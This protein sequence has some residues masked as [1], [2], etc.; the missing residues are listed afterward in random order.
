[1]LDDAFADFE[2]EVQS[3]E[4]GVA[5]LEI[6]HDAQGVQI[7]IEVEAVFAHGCIESFFAGVAE[8]G[9]ADVVDKSQRLGEIDV[10]AEC[11]GDGARDL[12]DFER[13]GE[14]V[15]EMVGITAGEDLSFRFQAAEGTGMDDAV[16][17]TLEI[18]AV[19]VRG[20]GETASAGVF[21]FDRVAGHGERI[22]LLIVD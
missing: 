10:E 19:G 13:V 11:S 15:A 4:G 21:Y 16:A 17:V 8:R 7:V 2:G 3:A 12:R 22:A 5:L 14:A 1:M 9:M 18:V 20:L 6:F